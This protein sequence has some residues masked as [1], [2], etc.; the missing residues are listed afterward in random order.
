MAV[1]VLTEGGSAADAA[2]TTLFCEGVVVAHHM[3]LGGG[4]LMTIYERQSGKVETLTAREMAPQKATID[5]FAGD[6][7]QLALYGG[8]AVAVPGELKGYWELHQKYGRLP[9]RR[10]VEPTIQLAVDGSVV[11]PV[12]AGRLRQRQDRILAEPTLREFLVNPE[13]NMTWEAGDVI[14]RP[15]LAESLEIIADEGANAIYSVNGSL[16]R[17]LV[18]DIQERGGIIDE[19]DFINYQ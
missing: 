18:E 5:M 19:A 3:G 9:W 4:F 8:L 17:P 15:K 6:R 16:L 13:T 1:D 2:I 14:K 10:L 11:T 12:L 7:R